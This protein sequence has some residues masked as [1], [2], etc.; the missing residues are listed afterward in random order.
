MRV[1]DLR[2]TLLEAKAANQIYLRTDT[3][4]NQF[5]SFAAYGALAR[6]LGRDFEG[7]RPTP[8]SEFEVSN[9]EYSGDL[10]GILGLHNVDS[11]SMPRLTPRRPARARYEGECRDVGQCASA[12]E[13]EAL[14]RLLMY[15]DSAS[16]SLIPF[17]AEHFGRAVYVWDRE[18]KFSNELIDAERPDVLVLEMV[19]RR[20]M[21][22]T[23]AS[24]SDA[25]AHAR[26]AP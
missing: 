7:V 9:V 26:I 19:E 11:E 8:A 17:L 18:W 4:W 25:N 15:R 13:G 5:G 3:H 24:P 12:L 21:D 2:P 23:P 14:P 1:L 6:E 22:P 16:I 10:A 20:L